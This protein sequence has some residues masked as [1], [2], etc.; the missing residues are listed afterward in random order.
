MANSGAKVSVF[1]RG[2]DDDVGVSGV[3]PPL[4]ATFELNGE[5]GADELTGGPN[6]DSLDGGPGADTLRG[7]DGDDELLAADGEVDAELDCGP[8]TDTVIR[9]SIDPAPMNCVGETDVI[10]FP[11]Q[12]AAT[13]AVTPPAIVQPQPFPI[14]KIRLRAT[15][16]RGR[17]I[18]LDSRATATCPVTS[19]LT[20]AVLVTASARAPISALPK[21]KAGADTRKVTLADQVLALKPGVSKRVRVK[22]SQSMS[23]L[24]RRAK[25]L[26]VKFRIVVTIP[27]AKAARASTATAIK[28]PR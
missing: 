20:C 3:N 23:G 13:P 15:A 1:A 9:D 2:G 7:G 21:G 24:F 8:G 26:S 16:K 6:A 28:A 22:L 11:A 4:T 14:G 17:Q 18:T 5:G 12:P 25:R 10:V 19:Q 27:G